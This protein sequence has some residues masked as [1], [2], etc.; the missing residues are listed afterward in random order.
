MNIV[1]FLRAKPKVEYTYFDAKKGYHTKVWEFRWSG[2]FGQGYYQLTKNGRRHP[3]SKFKVAQQV[4]HDY[5][6]MDCKIVEE[7]VA[8]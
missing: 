2:I 6:D 3:M 7:K 8:H 4:Y 1:D 5:M